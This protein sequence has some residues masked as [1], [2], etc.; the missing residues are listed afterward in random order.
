MGKQ[1]GYESLRKLNYTAAANG[2]SPWVA[3]GINRCDFNGSIFQMGG[4][5]NLTVSTTMLDK[6]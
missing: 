6:G 1:G 5:C 3:Q 2:R 4:W